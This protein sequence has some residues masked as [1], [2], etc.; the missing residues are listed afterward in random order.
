[1]VIKRR[2]VLVPKYGLVILLASTL[3]I[4]LFSLCKYQPDPGLF[5]KLIDD[6]QFVPEITLNFSDDM[7]DENFELCL[8]G[9]FTYQ[10]NMNHSLKDMYHNISMRKD[11]KT[12]Q[13]KERHP[14]YK[15]VL[16]FADL[17]SSLN[18]EAVLIEPSMLFCMLSPSNK[19]LLTKRKFELKIESNSKQVVTFGIFENYTLLLEKAEIQAQI[20]NSNFSVEVIQEPLKDWMAKSSSDLFISHLFFS[21]NLFTIHV[22][23]FY[24]RGTYLWHST[25][26][27]LLYENIPSLEGLY[28]VEHD[29]AYDS[30]TAVFPNVTDKALKNVSIPSNPQYF[31][32]EMASSRFL[33]C[34]SSIASAFSKHNGADVQKKSRSPVELSRFKKR[35]VVALR[36]LKAKLNP[37]LIHFWIWSGTMLGWY[38]ECGVI[39]YT[40]DV[41]FAA[42]AEEVDNLDQVV[43]LFSDDKHLKLKQRMGI[44][45]QGLELNLN[46]YKVRVDLFFLYKESNGTWYA[47]HRPSK[48]YYFKYHHPNFTLCSAELLGHKVMVPCQ[49]EG[50]IAME[51]GAKWMVP[52]AKWNYEHSIWNRGPNIYWEKDMLKTVYT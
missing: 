10:G 15:V 40:S 14:L 49:T 34:N 2:L 45:E 38:R 13:H 19:E 11:Y 22:V 12:E 37:L 25:L 47:G 39:P 5:D 32:F 28:F 21:K 29:S 20:K 9:P 35:T 42:W 41:D 26:K 8:H 1:M 17:M 6:S 18:I 44:V 30:L 4:T 52:V 24:S 33:E 46:C 36:Q 23:V 31:L 16:E 51:Y 50:V 43:K 27:N 3:G 48:G 7:L